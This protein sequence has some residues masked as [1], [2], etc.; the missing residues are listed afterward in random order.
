MGVMYDKLPF[1]EYLEGKGVIRD[2]KKA[3][4]WYEKAVAQGHAS[5]MNNL[6]NLYYHADGVH[7]DRDKAKSLWQKAADLG[8]EKAKDNLKKLF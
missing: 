8:D 3:A 7:L 6:A 1:D 2:Y 5:A 4:E